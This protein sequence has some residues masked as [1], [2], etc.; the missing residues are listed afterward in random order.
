MNVELNFV[1]WYCN[2]RI[3]L[4]GAKKDYVFEETLRDAPL[5]DATKQ[6]SKLFWSRSNDY[7]DVQCTLLASMEPEHQNRFEN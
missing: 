2:V 3:I 1:D 5:D 7:I 4:K 6:S